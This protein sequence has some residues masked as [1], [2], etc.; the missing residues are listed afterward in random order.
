MRSILK[1]AYLILL[2]PVWGPVFLLIY[3]FSFQMIYVMALRVINRTSRPLWITLVG[4]FDSGE[5]WIPLR[6]VTSIPAIPAV[7]QKNHRVRPGRSRQVLFDRKGMDHYDIVVR[8]AKGEHRMLVFDP[9]PSRSNLYGHGD[10]N[11]VIE[12]WNMLAPVPSDVLAKALEPGKG[13]VLWALIL[14]GFP[15]FVFYCWLLEL[16]RGAAK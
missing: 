2:T 5:R 11:Y 3:P 8:N 13:W 6:F 16:L 15:M 4:T 9:V 1:W 10:A 7:R 12:D 14:L